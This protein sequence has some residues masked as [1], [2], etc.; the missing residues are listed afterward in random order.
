[1]AG[2]GDTPRPMSVSKKTWDAEYGRIFPIKPAQRKW[3]RRGWDPAIQ[4]W[5]DQ[6]DAPQWVRADGAHECGRI[7]FNQPYLGPID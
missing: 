4:D 7:A 1:M 2:K 6:C 5:C 3:L